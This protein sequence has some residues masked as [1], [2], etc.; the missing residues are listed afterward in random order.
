MGTRHLC[1]G[2]VSVHEAVFA[3]ITLNRKNRRLTIS[4][5]GATTIMLTLRMA[6]HLTQSAQV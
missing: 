1:A 2:K 4:E 3:T 6:W 5:N